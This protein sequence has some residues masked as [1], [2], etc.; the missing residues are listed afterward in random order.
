LAISHSI[1]VV[2]ESVNTEETLQVVENRSIR[3]SA[4]GTTKR[5][6]DKVFVRANLQNAGYGLFAKVGR[7]MFS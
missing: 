1:L 3:I 2:P 6:G 5:N 7:V 4:L